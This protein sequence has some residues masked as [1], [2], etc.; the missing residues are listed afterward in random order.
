MGCPRS[1]KSPVPAESRSSLSANRHPRKS[2]AP[3]VPWW[4]LEG[5]RRGRPSRRR[6]ID[7][8]VRRQ[9]LQR[10]D[11]RALQRA[12]RW[13]LE[14]AHCP[15]PPP[16]VAAPRRC[17]VLGPAGEGPVGAASSL[18]PPPLTERTRRCEGCRGAGNL[19]AKLRTRGKY[20][21][22]RIGDE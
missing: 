12:R 21:G 9:A 22:G 14:G 13:G 10:A 5:A 1:C 20:R 19:T 4:A 6:S 17:V 15:R 8:G 16:A 7:R 2:I 11:R 3:C 18:L